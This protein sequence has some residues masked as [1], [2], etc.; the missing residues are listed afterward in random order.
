MKKYPVPSTRVTPFTGW[1]SLR[2]LGR[3]LR[4]P[5]WRHFNRNV[6]RGVA[7]LALTLGLAGCAGVEIEN[8][9][10]AQTLAQ[11]SKP[12]GS[13]YI[14]WRVYQDK[15]LACHGPQATGSGNAPNLLP[16]LKTM[17]PRQF[18]SLVLQRYDWNQ[19]AAKTGGSP[20]E[21]N[22]LV[23]TVMQRQDAPLNMPAWEGEPR[24]QAHIADLYAYLS[25]RAAGTQGPERP[26]P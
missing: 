18:V 23:E 14:G 5:C 20:Q 7:L 21:K 12:P 25:A 1:V 16:L 4:L 19:M 2:R 8:T 17:G 3:C 26:V 9:Q 15:C 11:T 22:A 10:A 6:G 13:V 24:V